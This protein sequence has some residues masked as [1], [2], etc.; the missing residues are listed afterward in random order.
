MWFGLISY[1]RDHEAASLAWGRPPKTDLHP[2]ELFDDNRTHTYIYIYMCEIELKSTEHDRYTIFGR[3]STV[4]TDANISASYCVRGGSKF[5]IVHVWMT[6]AFTD[7]IIRFN[8]K[9]VTVLTRIC[10]CDSTNASHPP[11]ASNYDFFFFLIVNYN[12]TYPLYYTYVHK[13]MV[14]LYRVCCLWICTRWKKWPFRNYC[15]GDK[16]RSLNTYNT[17]SLY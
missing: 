3:A 1:L 5:M 15:F 13:L 8:N 7:E 11:H 14:T 4:R 6:K 16:F 10:L 2:R 17:L 12:R 9:I